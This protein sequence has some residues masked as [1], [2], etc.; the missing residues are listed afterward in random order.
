VTP[1]VS[2]GQPACDQ[3][4]R[5]YALLPRC[6]NRDGAPLLPIICLVAHFW[7]DAA[8]MVVTCT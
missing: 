2:R 3:L 7:V 1:I 8:K 6:C 5:I 4:N